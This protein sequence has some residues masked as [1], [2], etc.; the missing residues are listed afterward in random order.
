MGCTL[1]QAALGVGGHQGE[2]LSHSRLA[3]PGGRAPRGV[4]AYDD[5]SASLQANGDFTLKILQGAIF[6]I[7]NQ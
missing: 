6:L 4:V 1:W 3:R 7:G 2:R 5:G